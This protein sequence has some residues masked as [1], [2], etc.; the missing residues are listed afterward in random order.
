MSERK[1]E[2]APGHRPRH[3]AKATNVSIALGV[4]VALAG[5]VAVAGWAVGDLGLTALLT[6]EPGVKMNTGLLLICSGGALAL[7]AVRQPT[8]LV[9]ALCAFTIVVALV[10]LAE[11]VT[12]SAFGIDELLVS[13]GGAGTVA[14]GR[15]GPNTATCLILIA[16]SILCID[17]VWR[18]VAIGQV[19]A[20]LT[21]IIAISSGI[22]YFFGVPLAQKSL[23]TANLTPMGVHTAAAMLLLACGIVLARPEIGLLDRLNSNRP[24]AA[25]LR[26]LIAPAILLPIVLGY[27]LV[28]GERAGLYGPSEG[29]AVFGS[30]LAV[31]LVIAVWLTANAIDRSDARR[32][33][34]D[35]RARAVL[36][37]AVDGVITIDI[38][39]RIMDV[40]PAAEAMFG[41]TRKELIGEDMAEMI[42][43][44]H[45]RPEHRAGLV[46]VIHKPASF[47]RLRL[48][49]TGLRADGTEFPVEISIGRP[50]GVDP[51]MYVG[52]L[53]DISGAV[54]LE[55]DLRQAQK[56]EA[57][58]QLA[59]GIAHDFNNLLTVILGYADIAK[60]E[61]TDD[62]A[63]EDLNHIAQSA[64]RASELVRQLLA[65]SRQQVL[66]PE[67]LSVHDVV[68][69]LLPILEPLIGE[70]IDFELRA[71]QQPQNVFVDRGQLE[72][73]LINLAVNARDAMPTGGSLTIAVSP[74]RFEPELGNARSKLAPGDYVC[75][76]VAD[77]GTGIDPENLD[78]VF[79]PFFTTKEVGEGTGLGLATSHGIIT[80]SG[81]DIH[82][83]SEP[84]VGTTFNVYLP[85]NPGQVATQDHPAEDTSNH[86]GSE[87][88]LVCEDDGEV[89][90]LI[91]RILTEAGYDVVVTATPGEALRVMEQTGKDI[92]ALLTDVIMPEMSGPQ[93]AARI[94]AMDGFADL[95]VLLV[96]GYRPETMRDRGSLP[97]GSAHVAKPFDS[98]TL[99]AGL[100][101]VVDR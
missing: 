96:S 20:M 94:L 71:E 73:V 23:I 63:L 45:L 9:P 47:N 75:L 33:S 15:M 27:L 84:D 61:T 12:G 13:D 77:T 86:R 10:A 98:Q 43:P 30:F 59:G 35:A 48:R 51:P 2:H 22:G 6:G 44:E 14:P 56:M 28:S 7:R 82:V 60:Q 19:G 25:L 100:R 90:R 67:V 32:R 54:K 38:R 34:S 53:R 93:L 85:S 91:D 62:E 92:H 24:G 40:N 31:T 88:V 36:E 97:E 50:E 39:G 70:D 83:E 81:G 18:R 78:R 16:T 17:V 87:R 64:D 46:R 8:P 11:Y 3:A 26:R 68:T 69:G 79:E 1:S 21:G 80:Q 37:T 58:G 52:N 66:A 72:Q 74:A 89:R 4:L 49:S 99:L 29:A 95:P 101:E 55:D 5:F 76:T 65:F 42:V 41:Y 57:V